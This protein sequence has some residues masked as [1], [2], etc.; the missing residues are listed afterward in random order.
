VSSRPNTQ[1]TKPPN[2]SGDNLRRSGIRWRIKPPRCQAILH[3]PIYSGSRRQIILFL[4]TDQF[5]TAISG[6]RS[7]AQTDGADLGRRLNPAGFSFAFA[8]YGELLTALFRSVLLGVADVTGDINL[9]AHR[10]SHL[11]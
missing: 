9:A 6:L 2:G 8:G 11:L 5:W 10:R 7:R 1:P 4:K 3:G